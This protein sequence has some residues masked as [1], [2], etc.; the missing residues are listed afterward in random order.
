MA[1]FFRFRSI[2]SLLGKF[3]ELE[4]QTIYFASPEELDDPMEGLRNIVWNGDQIVWNH[5]FKHYTFCLNRCYLPLNITPRPGKLDADSIPI[6]ERWDQITTP[7]EKNLFNDIWDRFCNLPYTQEIIEALSNARH[8]IRYREIVCYLRWIQT[9]VLL[10]EIRKTYIDHG[11]ISEPLIPRPLEESAV[12][13]Q[14]EQLLILITN[15]E[16]ITDERALDA[17]LYQ[18]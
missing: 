16:A 17:I 13:V 4:Q 15:T 14:M 10:D 9:S 5:F 12:A 7:I 6:L 8:K 1:E 3:Q 11:I 2:D 18:F